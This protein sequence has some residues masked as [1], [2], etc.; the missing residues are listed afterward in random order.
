MQEKCPFF[1]FFLFRVETYLKIHD[2]QEMP[3]RFWNKFR[4][5]ILSYFH[6]NFTK[7]LVAICCVLCLL[8]VNGHLSKSAKSDLQK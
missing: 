3:K 1:L 6:I 8:T 7:L 5:F 2:I 4:F